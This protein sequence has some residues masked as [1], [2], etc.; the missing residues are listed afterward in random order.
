MS[1]RIFFFGSMRLTPI[2]AVHFV[3]LWHEADIPVTLRMSAFG[4]KAD[5]KRT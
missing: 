4:G 2:T 5:M 1:G 3:R